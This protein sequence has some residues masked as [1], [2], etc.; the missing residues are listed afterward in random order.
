MALFEMHYRSEALS[1]EVTVNVILPEHLKNTN[2]SY[3]TLYLLHGYGGAYSSWLRRT[4]IERFAGE[5]GIAVVMPDAYNSWY[6]DTAYGAK[7]FTFVTDELVRVCRGYFKGMSDKREDN[8]I[9]GLSMGG[10]GAIKAAMTYPDRYCGCISLSGSLDITRKG[11][12]Y[13][14]D[15]WKGN[16]GFDLESAAELEGGENDVF[17]L[18]KKCKKDG[19]PMPR[20]FLWCG[21]EDSLIHINRTY[22]D[23]LNTLGVKHVYTESEG[24]HSWKWWNKHIEVALECFFG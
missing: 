1:T 11:R 14:V 19:K 13:S 20:I 2:E 9:G 12:P 23:F 16:F 24:D 7:Y 15:L 22:R 8:F 5:H 17:A 3:K 6:A 21:T 4:E 18:T 10:Y